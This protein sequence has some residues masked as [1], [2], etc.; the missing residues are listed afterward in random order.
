MNAAQDFD[1]RVS[2]GKFDGAVLKPKLFSEEHEIHARNVP[3]RYFD[4]SLRGT[5]SCIATSAVDCAL[6]HF[7]L[8]PGLKFQRFRVS[9][10]VKSLFW[11]RWVSA[12]ALTMALHRTPPPP[13]YLGFH[14][15]S[16]FLMGETL[17]DYLDVSSPW[18]FPLAVLSRYRAASA[19]LLSGD[20]VCL[21]NLLVAANV[22]VTGKIRCDAS[23][24]TLEDASYDTVTSLWASA[25][26]PFKAGSI[27]ELWRVLRPGGSLLLSVPCIGSC[28]EGNAEQCNQSILAVGPRGYDLKML[29]RRLFAVMGLPRRYAIYGAECAT[30]QE[31]S[32]TEQSREHRDDLIAIGRH[33]RCYANLQE[34]PGKGVIVMKFVR[35]DKDPQPLAAVQV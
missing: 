3:R 19:T 35:P 14:F 32:N 1:R 15:A 30:L 26:S 29:E 24:Q 12:P 8:L 18:L 25:D 2:S 9:L 23:D 5:F 10:G 13:A 6:A 27:E 34:L 7:Y 31:S 20:A 17:G 16:R 4:G 28:A 21:Q 33:W 11:R 22:K